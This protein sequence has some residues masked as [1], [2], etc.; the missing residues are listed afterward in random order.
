MNKISTLLASFT[1]FLIALAPYTI[2]VAQSLQF[3]NA[4]LLV[5]ISGSC[6][7]VHE[8]KLA[9]FSSLFEAD[10]PAKIDIVKDSLLRLSGTTLGPSLY[11][12]FYK[13]QYNTVLLNPNETTTLH[14]KHL[15][16]DHYEVDFEGEFE[17]IFR[18]SKAY[19]E[20]I[21]NAVF[22]YRRSPD[23]KTPLTTFERAN[24]FR[25]CKLN[26]FKDRIAF[27]DEAMKPLTVS[28]SLKNKLTNFMKADLILH[29]DSLVVRHN[30]SIGLASRPAPKRDVSYYEGLLDIT[31]SDPDLLMFSDPRFL[32]AVRKD[33]VLNL[34]NLMHSSPASY[35]E[36]LQKSLPKQRDLFYEITLVGAYLDQMND[37]TPLS[38][39]Q[40]VAINGYFTNPQI[41]NYLYFKNAQGIPDNK[42]S[43][44]KYYLPFDNAQNDVL[45]DILSKY[46]GKV[47]IV[48][49]WATWCGPCIEAF[50]DIKNVKDKYASRDDVVFVYL[51]DQSSDRTRWNEYAR[52]ISGDHYY[53]YRSQLSSINNMY[54]IESIPSYLIFDKHSSLSEKS[55]GG[56]MGNDKLMEWIESS[57]KK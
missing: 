6:D 8:L 40:K 42:K 3:G 39:S 45:N 47:V 51:T 27:A 10:V 12:F 23:I 31:Y 53:L 41:S 5:K 16:C 24:D 56:Y 9:H 48:D 14:I 38:A 26:E 32:E 34:P 17:D 55:I 21:K 57:L 30:R 37:G 15:D 33:S 19:G 54:D 29:Y 46:K 1:F 13:D 20:L 25:D 43:S 18:Q 44:V 52:I 22:G 35:R 36:S 4:N 49:F 2:V 7:S 50:D 11:Y 28:P